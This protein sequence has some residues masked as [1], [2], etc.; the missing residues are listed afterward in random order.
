MFTMRSSILVI[1]DDADDIE[2]IQDAFSSL[3]YPNVT[4]CTSASEAIEHL[5]TAAPDRL[6][7]LIVTDNSVPA[8]EG[9]EFI[10]HVKE[11]DQYAAIKVVV[12]STHV[13]DRNKEKL[14]NAGVLKVI[15]KPQSF[16]GYLSLSLSLTQLAEQQLIK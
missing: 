10:K 13:S 3:Q 2:I 15:N 12:L 6:P 11:V 1:D 7:S 14:L 4:Y 9:F 8:T 16:P 5:S